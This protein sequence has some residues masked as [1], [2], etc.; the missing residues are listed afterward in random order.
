MLSEKMR[1]N[2]YKHPSYDSNRKAL[3]DGS[4]TL[5]EMWKN[6]AN[7]RRNEEVFGKI[8]AFSKVIWYNWNEADAM[9]KKLASFLAKITQKNDLIGI[10][11]VNR[12]EWL[13][14][15]YAI[16]EINCITCPLYSTFGVEAV[17][18]ILNET[19]MKVCIASIVKAKEL[20]KNIISKYST[21]LT[22]IIIMDSD[23]NDE[24]LI[25]L[26]NE[27][28]IKIH[29]WNDIMEKDM[30]I[31]VL[32]EIDKPTGDDL[33]TICY[34]SGTSGIPKG[35]MLTHTNF[36]STMA[37]FSVGIES[38]TY[39]MLSEGE[40]Y[41]SYLPLAHV[42]ERLCVNVSL[43]TKGKIAFF[44]GNTKDFQLECKIVRP[45]YIIGVP[46]VFNSIKEKVESA[47][48][49]KGML[50][51]LVFKLALQYKIFKQKFGVFKCEIL[52]YLIFSRIKNEFGGRI[53]GILS[54]SASLNPEVLGFLQAVFSIRVHEGYGQTESTAAS[55]I[56]PTDCLEKGIVGIPFPTNLVKLTPVNGYENNEGEICLKGPNITKGYFKRDDLTREL[57]DDEGFLRTGDIGSI[58]N[59][60]FSIIGRK[61]EIFKTSLG[62]YI[63]PEKVEDALRCDII[64]DILIVGRM[65]EDYI[66][67][68]VISKDTT[69]GE[70]EIFMKINSR[71]LELVNKGVI[72]KYEIPRKIYVL[73]QG[74]EEYGDFL[75][76][77]GKKKRKAIEEHFK[78]KID[79]LYNK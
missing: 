40:I 68:L 62:E 79:S 8:N 26:Y 17:R 54:G 44:R 3:K 32:E 30:D 48:K 34:T 35:V 55:I 4:T 12:V 46:R 74:F 60:I 7:T 42:M 28:G 20:L 23:I 1:E 53:K 45:D 41:F 78:S 39:P 31:G 72:M 22:D 9:M 51:Y 37:G 65:Y 2:I 77:T 47:V 76:P 57:F 61:K 18:H 29:Y 67:A 56:V 33:A 71:G 75:T 19:E 10:Y 69:I 11:S 58:E 5:L 66:V 63:I 15:E 70:N 73:R 38:K 14:S 21:K 24:S 6:L 27:K 64:S 43:S 50:I 52:D 25:E 16:Y 13:I 49:A 36:I 59:G